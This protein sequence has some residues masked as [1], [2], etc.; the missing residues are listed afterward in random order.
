MTPSPSHTGTTQSLARR[1][2]RKKRRQKMTEPFD[3]TEKSYS[4]NLL[5]DCDDT[6]ISAA[7]SRPTG[8]DIVSAAIDAVEDNDLPFDCIV[9]NLVDPKKNCIALV[10][11]KGSSDPELK[12][13]DEGD[14]RNESAL[15]SM[16]SEDVDGHIS[17]ADQICSDTEL[18]RGDHEID[19]SSDQKSTQLEVGIIETCSRE[20][21]LENGEKLTLGN[22]FEGAKDK[23]LTEHTRDDSAQNN[24]NVD[25]DSINISQQA[26]SPLH[27]FGA[28]SLHEEI[29]HEQNIEP[30]EGVELSSLES[31]GE[32]DSIS[33]GDH[34]FE[35]AD[36]SKSLRV[37]IVIPPPPPTSRPPSPAPVFIGDKTQGGQPVHYGTI[38][39][40]VSDEDRI[41][42]TKGSDGDLST[43][44]PP[45]SPS[46]PRAKVMGLGDRINIQQTVSYEEHDDGSGSTHNKYKNKKLPSAFFDAIMPPPPPPFPPPSSSSPSSKLKK[47]SDNHGVRQ[48]DDI[49]PFPTD[50]EDTVELKDSNYQSHSTLSLHANAQTIDDTQVAQVAEIDN[51]D[52]QICQRERST[53]P[54]ETIEHPPPPPKANHESRDVQITAN[55]NG[56]KEI[57]QR[58][59]STSLAEKSIKNMSEQ[60]EA[61]SLVGKT[62]DEEMEWETGED[63]PQKTQSHSA[64][65]FEETIPENNNV[66]VSFIS[67]VSEDDFYFRQSIDEPFAPRRIESATT[68]KTL[69]LEVGPKSHRSENVEFI[70]ETAIFTNDLENSSI[71]GETGSPVPT[72]LEDHNLEHCE[73]KFF[74]SAGTKVSPIEAGDHTVC[75]DPGSALGDE[76]MES[77]LSNKGRNSESPPD[78]LQQSPKP[79]KVKMLS[80]SPMSPK[81]AEKIALASS[82]ADKKFT[83]FMASKEESK[84]ASNDSS[85]DLLESTSL[86]EEKDLIRGAFTPLSN[87]S[88][89]CI[90]PVGGSSENLLKFD[91]NDIPHNVPELQ[92][93]GIPKQL[94]GELI[95]MVEV[96]L[97][98]RPLNFRSASSLLK[99][100]NS[101]LSNE[102]KKASEGLGDES[103]DNCLKIMKRLLNQ[104]HNINELCQYVTDSVREGVSSS[105]IQLSS[106][107]N[108]STIEE[109]AMALLRKSDELESFRVPSE[110]NVNVL[111]SNFAAFVRKIVFLTGL[112]SPMNHNSLNCSTSI[113]SSQVERGGDKVEEDSLQEQIFGNDFNFVAVLKFFRKVTDP[114]AAETPVEI[115]TKDS[116]TEHEITYNQS[117]SGD[118]ELN[119]LGDVCLTPRPSMGAM[120]KVECLT[121]RRDN[122]SSDFNTLDSLKIPPP[123][124][125]LYYKVPI[126]SPSPL[127]ISVWNV[128][129]IVLIVLGCLGD[130]VAV[131]RMKMV[132]KFC[133][134][135]INEN[136]YVIMKDSVRLGGISNNIRPAF[137][138]WITLDRCQKLEREEKRCGDNDRPFNFKELEQKGRESQWHQIIERDVIR[139]F[140]NF[141]PHKANGSRRNSIVRALVTWGQNHLLRRHDD[142]TCRVV[143]A[144]TPSEKPIR[145]LTMSPPPRRSKTGTFEGEIALQRSE[146]VSDWGG[147]SPVGS[148]IS[149]A[150]SLTR[151]NSL[152]LVLAGNELTVEMK[153]DLQRK[154]GSILDVIAAVHEGF[155]YC[156]GKFSY[157]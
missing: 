2:N 141:P 62:N 154:L 3:A 148:N 113:D 114:N 91:C 31:D 110:R 126:V 124:F 130:P 101:I 16:G 46:P 35:Q 65:E 40:V 53:S 153:T 10:S 38:E 84:H 44:K 23:N 80:T 83:D 61:E 127:E 125:S 42:E 86:K 71:D 142:G 15:D 79:T 99:W 97:S 54:A 66:D 39:P 139:A 32:D 77:P 64:Q 106:T 49:K 30:A 112:P 22:K 107:E 85:Y 55:G 7:D 58:E 89:A 59:I 129:S 104:E 133:N 18:N 25:H 140:G 111:A 151:S 156:Q 98:P 147:I 78:V 9:D 19:Q 119:S 136:E 70:T 68:S 118:I 137:W 100:L 37:G 56:V 132:N 88:K 67:E 21:I 8:S 12:N 4:T 73:K 92:L 115:I 50:E 135:I 157:P 90:S 34:Y 96:Q 52:D 1:S 120:K 60:P 14:D 47:Q 94:D 93:G 155:G 150:G 29:K 105:N 72:S 131:C 69:Q 5:K 27:T 17:D 75:L 63:E 81:M 36:T 13:L 121:D 109:A 26:T 41:V 57:C 102:G 143:P 122:R 108:K 146:T 33:D 28:I 149:S 95:G 76:V 45:L 117:C 103:R 152:E 51:G 123:R 116:D 134:R 20:N 6:F 24:E 48:D 74:N 145:R 128:P 82:R 144:S 138:M 11:V 43:M 87:S